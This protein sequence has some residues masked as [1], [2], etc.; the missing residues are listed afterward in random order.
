[1][2]KLKKITLNPLAITLLI[3]VLLS[4]IAI[5]YRLNI[6]SVAAWSWHLKLPVNQS[7]IVSGEPKAIRS[8]EWFLGVPWLLSQ[9]N[10]NPRWPTHN[11]A[12]GPG[13]AALLVGL[14][15]DHWS[16][17]FRPAHWGFYLFSDIERGFTWLWLWRSVVPFVALIILFLELTYGSIVLSLSAA[18]AVYFSGFVQWWLSS[19]GELLAYW[20]ISCLALRYLF[21]SKDPFALIT[22]ALT[23]LITS[24]A[25]ALALY[26]PFQVP[27]LYLGVSLTPLLLFKGVSDRAPKK[28]WR[29]ISLRLATLGVV[30]AAACSVVLLF[31]VANR[32]TI[33]VMRQTVYPG[34]RVS[35]GGDLSFWRL[36]SGFYEGSFSQ[37]KFAPVAGNISEASSFLFLW[38]VSAMV[39]LWRLFIAKF[40]GEGRGAGE[41]AG[42]GK[43]E[44]MRDLYLAIPILAYLILG[45]LWGFFGIS[46]SLATLSGLS[47][48]PTGRALIGWGI[49][50]IIFCMLVA[51]DTQKKDR[52]SLSFRFFSALIFVLLLTWCS[53]SFAAR[54]SSN[55]LTSSDYYWQGALVALAIV[56]LIF[57]L[58]KLFLAVIFAVCVIPHY[59]VN[60]LSK[61]LKVVTSARLVRAVKRFDPQGLSSWA[62]F[63]SLQDAQL[64]KVS[65]RE[66][67]N[68]SQY[69]P[70]LAR[71]RQL[72]PQGIYSGVY[73][74]YA[75]VAFSFVSA[76]APSGETAPSFKLLAP[77]TYEV[78][79]D[80]CHESF[81]NFGVQYLVWTDYSSKRSF[82]CYERIF[83][84]GDF[85]IFK[86]RAISGAGVDSLSKG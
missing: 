59:H 62:V 42:E 4:I 56:A 7:G 27:L 8:D 3:A 52:S 37:Y 32:E 40:G 60:P 30:L 11:R 9:A 68:G 20:S 49:A 5:A 39:L 81:K 34:Q 76:D 23:L 12:V 84:G 55:G 48:V 69:L 1:M 64:V 51:S 18:A 41:G 79:I 82:E 73:N 50:S 58:N 10:H 44:G 6:S 35:L 85:A 46:E 70:D 26:P 13:T 21:L 28:T 29:E 57:N 86:R 45:S 25:F 38:P 53:I 43:G 14:P 61:G 67:V 22:S 15:T 2:P 33:A 80:P 77:D 71:L 75:H 19:V 66:V 36:V 47:F 17:V 74:R 65:G 63:G 83:V 31:L 72:D 54:F 24:A 78:V 16:A